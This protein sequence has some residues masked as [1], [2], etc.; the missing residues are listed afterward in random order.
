M[1]SRCVAVNYTFVDSATKSSLLH[2]AI[3][4]PRPDHR[5]HSDR[6]ITPLDH[7]RRRP[8]PSCG[9]MKIPTGAIR[10]PCRGRYPRL[11]RSLVKKPLPSERATNSKPNNGAPATSTSPVLPQPQ[12]FGDVAS[13]KAKQRARTGFRFLTRRAVDGSLNRWEASPVQR[14]QNRSTQGRNS[15]SH[16]H[17]VRVCLTTCR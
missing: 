12:H 9:R 15:T 1:K 14:P 6:G 3:F 16:V 13:P 5:W 7:R 4:R 11:W 2:G 10:M 8:S 17:A